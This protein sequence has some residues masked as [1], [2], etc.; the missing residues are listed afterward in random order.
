M[1]L[2][3]GK[4]FEPHAHDYDP[5][6]RRFTMLVAGML[7]GAFAFKLSRWLLV[8]P[9]P[10]LEVNTGWFGK[11]ALLYH[12]MGV[13]HLL[14]SVVYFGV[15]FGVLQWWKLTNPLRDS[16]L[17][18]LSTIIAVMTAIIMHRFLPYPQGFLIAAVMSM[19]IQVSAP[20][21]THDQRR[22]L[23]EGGAPLIPTPAEDYS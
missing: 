20:W 21:L 16:R 8:E 10:L 23:A 3:I 14:T 4:F 1:V 12:G 17:S 15:M 13:P 19:A 22:K 6:L 5:I 18:V 9:I 2:G 11:N 7:L